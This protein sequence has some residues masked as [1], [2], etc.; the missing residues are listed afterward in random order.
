MHPSICDWIPKFVDMIS[1]K[2]LGQFD[3]IDNF[4]TIGDKGGEKR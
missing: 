2:P 1:Y 4:G 3:Q